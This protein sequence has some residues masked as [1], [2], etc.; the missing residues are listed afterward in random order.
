M[1]LPED[2]KYMQRAIQ[3]AEYGRGY[4]SPNPLVGCV[5][6]KNGEIIGEGWHRKYG[7][8]HAEVNAIESVTDKSQ[9]PGC[10]A[11]V[12]LEPCAHFGNTPP[13]ANRLV[14]E[15]VKKVIIGH[16]DPNPKVNGGGIK[17]LKE[18]G[19]EVEVGVLEEECQYQNRVF[20]TNMELDRPFIVLKWA[21]TSDGFVAREN[22]DSKWISNT[23]SRQQ[24]HK[25]RSEIDAI[26][27]GYNTVYY[28][29]PELTTRDWPGNNPVRV[30]L[31]PRNELK[32]K[33]LK[34]F[35]KKANTIIFN[36][37]ENLVDGNIHKIKLEDFDPSF[38][39]ERLFEAG[40]RS[41]LVEGGSITLG[42]W[43]NTGEWDEA[44]VYISP[45][46]FENGIPAPIIAGQ[47]KLQKEKQIENDIVQFWI[48]N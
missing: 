37:S 17:I 15:K 19:I 8:N 7:E 34:I 24:V 13:C 29:N 33:R 21:Q 38:V 5:L 26:L 10:T 35:N 6:V 44:H 18:A 32:D 47:G 9:I 41:V 46:T 3:L 27:V 20:L 11:Y 28:D 4:V 14:E 36:S 25:L 2:K 39:L 23:L 30:V 22:F 48:N 45:V 1:S 16:R 42:R 40:I 31:D 43:I 12:T